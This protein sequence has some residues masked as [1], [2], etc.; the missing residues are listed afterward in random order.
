MISVVIPHL[1]QA[2]SLRRCLASLSEQHGVRGPVEIIVVDNGS[3]P[4]PAEV[5]A[6]F[7]GVVLLHQPM[8][9]P[10]PA[11]N[12]GVASAA[13]DLLAF[14]DADCG[15]REGW[16]SAIERRFAAL[17]EV[18]ILGGNVRILCQDSRNPTLIEA[19]E[20]V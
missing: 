9:G 16:L 5:C 6:S 10:G 12:M 17:P 1:N 8:P 4:P 20:S 15:A 2:E 13:G 3:T 11:R 18:T 14:I 7:P 19:Y